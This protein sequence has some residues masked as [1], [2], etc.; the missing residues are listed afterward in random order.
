MSRTPTEP[1]DAPSISGRAELAD[2]PSLGSVAAMLLLAVIWGLSIPVTKVG[3]QSLPPLTL[4]AWRFAVAVPVLMIFAVGQRRMPWRALLPIAALGVVGIGVG[5][6]AQTFGVV[7]TSAS[8]ATIITATIPVFVVLFAA[9]R[10]KQSVSSRQKLG[11]LAAFIGIAMVALGDGQGFDD[12]FRSSA[13]GA[14]WVLLSAIAI[15]FYYVWSVELAS[16]YGTATVAAWSTLF[17]FLAFVPWAGW[18]MSRVP[19]D[20]TWEAVAAVVYLGAVV[21]V[22]G[23]FLWLSL[24]STVQARIAASVQFLQPVV[25]VAAS[26][27]VFGD[28]M[29]AFVIAGVIL[30]FAGVALTTTSRR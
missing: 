13:P 15:A 18:E 29:G 7:D 20:I 3:L 2:A 28:R 10:L 22:A 25:G 19:F 6:V 12:L 5:Q 14:A 4:T 16:Q 17:G 26:A 23:L 11:L 1:C 24:L 30:V 9:L 27:A 8:V 21:T